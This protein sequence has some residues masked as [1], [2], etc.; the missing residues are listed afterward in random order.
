MRIEE[1]QWWVLRVADFDECALSATP[2]ASQVGVRVSWVSLMAGCMGVPSS[3]LL[4][5]KTRKLNVSET[6]GGRSDPG[7]VRVFSG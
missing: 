5:P 3:V 7:H 4:A 6:F 1:M 2:T